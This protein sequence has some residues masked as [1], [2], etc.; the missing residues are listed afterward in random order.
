MT[1]RNLVD[2]PASRSIPQAIADLKAAMAK[3]PFN[4]PRR[5]ALAIQ[6][7][8]LEDHLEAQAGIQQ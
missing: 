6:I 7:V 8:R 2:P 4:D 3:A 1:I 5:A